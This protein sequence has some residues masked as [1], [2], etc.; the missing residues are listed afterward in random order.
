MAPS[1]LIDQGL[2]LDLDP[3]DGA[4]FYVGLWG[5]ANLQ[6]LEFNCVEAYFTRVPVIF[7]SFSV[8]FFT[9]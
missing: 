5:R 3:S 2:Y 8:N 1:E 9:L 6:L 4:K 7:A